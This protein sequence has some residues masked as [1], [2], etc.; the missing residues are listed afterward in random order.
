MTVKSVRGR[1]RYIVFT[2]GDCVSRQGVALA[3]QSADSE[4]RVVTVQNGMAVVRTSP[5]KTDDVVKTVTEKIPG[6]VPLRTSGTLKS[7]RDR[8]T[9]LRKEPKPRTR[10]P[11]SRP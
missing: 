7:L 10:H 9:G 1:R 3:A 11:N 8:Y 4:S 2:V 5:A 6:S